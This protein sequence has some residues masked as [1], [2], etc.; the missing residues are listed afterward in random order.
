MGKLLG[1]VKGIFRLSNL[2]VMQQMTIGV[3]TENG[4]SMN[5]SPIGGGFDSSNILTGLM[6][7]GVKNNEKITQMIDMIGKLK[8]IDQGNASRASASQ[9]N[10]LVL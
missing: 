5:V 3:L 1:T 2:P 7:K 9:Q 4:I 8:K 10:K 6:K